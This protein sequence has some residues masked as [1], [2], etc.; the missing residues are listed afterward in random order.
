MEVTTD[1][2]TFY[3]PLPGEQWI[4]INLSFAGTTSVGVSGTDVIVLVGDN[5]DEEEEEPLVIQSVRQ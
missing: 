2:L 4:V 1:G 3:H 5:E